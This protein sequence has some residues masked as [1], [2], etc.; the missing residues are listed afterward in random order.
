MAVPR[1]ASRWRRRWCFPGPRAPGP[2][3][4]SRAGHLQSVAA[5][6]ISWRRSTARTATRRPRLSASSP[7]AGQMRS[8]LVVDAAPVDAIVDCAQRL[9]ARAI[10]V[11]S[12]T[13]GRLPRLLLG[14]VAR[15]VVETGALRHA[16]GQGASARLHAV[17]CGHRWVA[18]LPE[19]GRSGGRPGPAASGRRDAGGDRRGPARARA[20]ARA[21]LGPAGGHPGG[22]GGERASPR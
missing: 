12:R 6:D 21:C 4:W 15:D 9:G 10:A 17:R 13:R 16:R 18:G 11:G 7:P 14:S 5:P 8:V 2:K 20:S 1:P 19:R 3:A 22:G